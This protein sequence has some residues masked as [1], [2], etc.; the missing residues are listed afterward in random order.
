MALLIMHFPKLRLLWSRS[1][2]ET[3]KILKE[4][5]PN[6]QEVDIEKA[7]A[8]GSNESIDALLLGNGDNDDGG[9]DGTDGSKQ[10]AVDINEAGKE[11]LLRLPGITVHNARKVM[12]S[13]DNIAELASLFREEMEMLLGPLAGQK[14]FTFFHQ[15]RDYKI[16]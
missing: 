2:Y 3:L 8:V 1:P 16:K 12:Q 9:G 13:C 4:L 11:M 5:K 14:L 7:V 6:H 15:K 10:Q